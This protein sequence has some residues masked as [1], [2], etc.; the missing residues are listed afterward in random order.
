MTVF[1]T[2]LARP[3][4]SIFAALFTALIDLGARSP[5]AQKMERLNNMSDAQLHAQGLR[6]E[7]ISRHVLG[8]SYY[9]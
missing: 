7:D 9:L 1:T 3:A 2:K 4:R 8:G 5:L 6:R